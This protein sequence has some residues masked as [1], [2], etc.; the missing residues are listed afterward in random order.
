MQRLRVSASCPSC[1]APFELL[2]G[3]NV[4][5]CSYCDL[6]LL[7]QSQKNILR[8]YL[9]P[10]F[11]KRSIPFLVDRFRKERGLSLP[12]R[13]EGIQLLY[14]PFWRFTAQAFYTIVEQPSFSAIPAAPEVEPPTEEVFT[15]DW[16]VNFSAHRSND[17]GVATLG[18]RPDWLKLKILTDEA[19]L[20]ELGSVLSVEMDSSAAREKALRSLG[21]YLDGKKAP[22]D[23]LILQLV[24]ERLSLIYF[25]LWVVNF[26]AAEGKLFHVIDGI[27]K[28]ILTE[29]SGDFELSKNRRGDA[30]RFHPLNIVPHRCPNCG[31]DLPVAPF[32]VVFPCQNCERIWKLEEGTYHKITGEAAKPKQECQM[33]ESKSPDYHPFWVFEMKAKDGGSASIGDIFKVLPSE[34]GLFSVKDKSKPFLFHIPA[35]EM[36]NLVK[37]PDLGLAFIRTQPDFETESVKREKLKGVFLT[38][39]D[40]KKMADILWLRLVSRKANLELDDWKHPEFLNGRIAWFPCCQEGAFLTDGLTGYSFQRVT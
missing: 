30:E 23:E 9:E 5:R 35:F 28:R 22:E 36:K 21:F 6:P 12:K 40:A 32:H 7:F 20:R 24:E 37:L 29:G 25:P 18:M 2:E 10:K 26:A 31:W 3:A 17:L 1:G 39:D 38:E 14:L 27:T 11:K 34:I 15:K 19:H 33:A 4:A 16:D 8:Y 13:L